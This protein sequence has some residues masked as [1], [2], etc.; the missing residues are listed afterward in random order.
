MASSLSASRS[1]KRRGGC[2]ALECFYIPFKKLFKN[3]FL[4]NSFKI[5]WGVKYFA[6]SYLVLA[7]TWR[8][9]EKK[10]F[11]F[12]DGHDTAKKKALRVQR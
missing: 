7:S 12:L 4:K 5:E 1:R 8:P 11:F 10:H 6:R 3:S 2:G 9:L